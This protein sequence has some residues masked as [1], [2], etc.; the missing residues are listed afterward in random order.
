M[1][2]TSE[3]RCREKRIYGDYSTE[4]NESDNHMLDIDNFCKP[5][6]EGSHDGYVDVNDKY[7]DINDCIRMAIEKITKLLEEEFKDKDM[8]KIIVSICIF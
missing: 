8:D 1:Y 3:I 7:N 6:H 4:T 2:P 5:D